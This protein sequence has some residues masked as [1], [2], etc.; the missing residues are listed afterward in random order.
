MRCALISR[1]LATAT[2]SGGRPCWPH[3]LAAKKGRR[4]A[5]PKRDGHGRVHGPKPPGSQATIASA[6]KHSRVWLHVTNGAESRRI[7]AEEFQ[8][9]MRDRATNWETWG[10]GRGS[11]FS[12]G[13]ALLKARR[14]IIGGRPGITKR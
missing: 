11:A 12:S 9:L 3:S 4:A 7:S 6:Y 8:R 2:E 10:D 14:T 1:S 13:L 5:V